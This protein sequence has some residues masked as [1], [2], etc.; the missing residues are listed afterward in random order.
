MASLRNSEF[1]T[2]KARVDVRTHAEFKK[3][4]LAVHEHLQNHP[5]DGDLFLISPAKAVAGLGFV[6]TDELAAHL[7][8]QLQRLRLIVEKTGPLYER[9]LAGQLSPFD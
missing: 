8:S 9:A 2:A 6:L 7:T 4:L 1:W 3:V 5:E